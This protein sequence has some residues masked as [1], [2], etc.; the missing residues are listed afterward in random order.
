MMII[1]V[2]DEDV[3]RSVH[4]NGRRETR[5][6]G[7][8]FVTRPNSLIFLWRRWWWSSLSPL[9]LIVLGEIG[10]TMMNSIDLTARPNLRL[11][12]LWRRWSCWSSSVSLLLHNR[13]TWRRRDK[14][15][16][17]P[18]EDK[19]IYHTFNQSRCGYDDGRFRS[20]CHRRHYWFVNDRSE[21]NKRDEVE[22][23]KS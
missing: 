18:W 15:G 5:M 22:D 17:L 8:D 10:S 4:L 16:H 9:L 19:T 23:Y 11:I 21:W 7:I 13:S 6:D 14:D 12:S 3:D 2:V 20:F 1:V